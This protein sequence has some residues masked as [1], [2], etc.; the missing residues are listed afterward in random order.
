MSN[1]PEFKG[2]HT[3]EYQLLQI[4][5]PHFIHMYDQVGEQ[6]AQFQPQR[7]LEIGCGDGALTYNILTKCPGVQ[8]TAIDLNG[9]SLALARDYLQ[10]WPNVTLHEAEALAYLQAQP[11]DSFEAVASIWCLH[12]INTPQRHEILKE[13]LRVLKPG[14]VFINGD[15]YAQS[16]ELHHQILTQQVS[17]YFDKWLPL[18]KSEFLKEWVLHM[19][20]DEA[21]VRFMPETPELEYMVSLGYVGVQKLY[22]Q[23]MEA[24]VVGYKP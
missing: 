24:I 18:G 2:Y 17:A 21:C 15:K 5:I 6:V 14:G 9:T 7:V 3:E 10:E 23:N 20:F 12:N 19:F 13:I 1:Y 8:L 16:P 11:N 22:R 4:A